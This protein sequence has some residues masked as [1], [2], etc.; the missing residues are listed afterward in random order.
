[1]EGNSGLS[2]MYLEFVGSSCGFLIGFGE[3]RRIFGCFPSVVRPSLGACETLSELMGS[4][5]SPSEFGFAARS[6]RVR[7]LRCLRLEGRLFGS[8][9][10]MVN[11]CTR[12]TP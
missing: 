9:R 4:V 11:D 8:V 5:G 2:T 12:E 3:S 7:L 6:L 10:R 1:M